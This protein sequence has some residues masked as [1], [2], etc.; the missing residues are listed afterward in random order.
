[1]IVYQCN[2]KWSMARIHKR[3]VK[4]RVSDESRRRHD[5]VAT[6]RRIW[7]WHEDRWNQRHGIK[8]DQWQ[9]WQI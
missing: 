3:W 1:M 6:Y 7:F 5:R 9:E 2:A 4:M 8:N